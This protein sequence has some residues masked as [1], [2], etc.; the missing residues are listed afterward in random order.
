MY[1]SY[2]LLFRLLKTVSWLMRSS[3]QEDAHHEGVDAQPRH[4]RFRAAAQGADHQAGVGHHFRQEE[5]Q[6]ER[7]QTRQ[8][9]C[10]SAQT[11]HDGRRCGVPKWVIKKSII[12]LLHSFMSLR[13]I[14]ISMIMF[15]MYLWVLCIM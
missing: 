6:H 7:V 5:D 13:V 11:A 14:K 2:F 8:R 12:L 10:R 4:Q 9:L 1:I 3:Y 15:I